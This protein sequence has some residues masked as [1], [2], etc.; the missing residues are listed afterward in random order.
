MEVRKV[1]AASVRVAALTCTSP[2]TAPQLPSHMDVADTMTTPDIDAVMGLLVT[3]MLV[4]EPKNIFDLALRGL[5]DEDTISMHGDFYQCQPVMSRQELRRLLTSRAVSANERNKENTR[6]HQ[7]SMPIHKRPR[8][9]SPSED[10]ELHQA[11]DQDDD[12]ADR[13][14]LEFASGEDHFMADDVA[15]NIVSAPDSLVDE[16]GPPIDVQQDFDIPLVANETRH[17][18]A[19]FETADP[20]FTRDSRKEISSVFNSSHDAFDFVALR[21]KTI[22]SRETRISDEIPQA[23]PQPT[24]APAAIL[25]PTEI[26]DNATLQLSLAEWSPP[27]SQHYYLANINIFPK[28]HLIGCLASAGLGYIELVEREYLSGV[29]LVIDPH[30]AVILVTWFKLDT[31][32]ENVVQLVEEQSWRYSKILLLFESYA[33]NSSIT[34]FSPLT[35]KA[36][37]R[38][39]R[40]LVMAEATGAMSAGCQIETA[41]PLSVQE[42]AIYVRA[43]G[44]RAEDEDTTDGMLW[45]ERDQWL[46]ADVTEVGVYCSHPA[47]D[48][49]LYRRTTTI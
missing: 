49:I 41:F 1:T 24:E 15:Q 46:L 44:D 33:G 35:V 8:L 10:S 12:N 18:T 34:P 30:N 39:R 31:E 14:F 22:E 40:T 13:E 20:L 42:A 45:V 6:Y 4:D 21:A 36:T 16:G 19:M 25:V 29:D 38:L 17:K 3:V 47:T 48:L 26:I 7:T 43:F 27:T 5:A 11:P 28:H 2:F 23:L 37:K 32:W 9:H